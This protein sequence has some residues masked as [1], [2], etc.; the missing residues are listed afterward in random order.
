MFWSNTGRVVP[1]TTLTVWVHRRRSDI[2]WWCGDNMLR[3]ALPKKFTGTCAVVTL[4][5]PV[6]V[7]KM[8]AETLE[9]VAEITLPRINVRRKRSLMG[10][11]WGEDPT[12]IDAIGIPPGVPDE[13]KLADKAA[14][15]FENL[16]IIGALFPVTPSKN[17]NRINTIHHNVQRLGNYTEAGLRAVHKQLAATSLM[18]FQNR[19]ALDMLLAEK[20]GVCGMFGEQCCTFIPNNAASDG[21]L[22]KGIEGL[23]TLNK[24]MKEHS[25]VDTSMWD[26]WLDQFGR[27]KGLA[28]S[29][30]MSV[31]VFAA[32]LTLCGCCCI[33]CIRA[34]IIKLINTTLGKV[35]EQIRETMNL[36]DGNN[37]NDDSYGLPGL[38]P[39]PDYEPGEESSL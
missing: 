33:P 22:T 31:A 28:A 4:L 15:G 21:Q 7:V 16:P 17:V 8:E 14:A 27:F 29:V 11:D 20:G 30:L 19:I 34:L 23:R 26:G 3:D 1:L 36:L 25:V 35:D 6:T 12:Y 5:V 18:A 38:F 10:V 32:L 9:N 2:W 37:D 24:K 13:Y 39:D